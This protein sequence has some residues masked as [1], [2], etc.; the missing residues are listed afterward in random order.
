MPRRGFFLPAVLA[1]AMQS[2]LLGLAL[3][4]EFV[5]CSSRANA[6]FLS[7]SPAVDM[8]RNFQP[9]N[10]CT[11][12]NIPVQRQRSLDM[13]GHA[14]AHRPSCS[15]RNPWMHHATLFSVR[16]SGA[17]ASGALLNSPRLPPW[18]TERPGRFLLQMAA[19]EASTATANEGSSSTRITVM[20]GSE[21]R[22]MDAMSLRDAVEQ[23][24][25]DCL[26][27]VH[28]KVLSDVG[29]KRLDTFLS[30]SISILSRSA[31]SRIV[32]ANN[33]I[34]NGKVPKCSAKVRVGDAISVTLPPPPSTDAEPE[35]I[36][37]Q[38]LLED[39]HVVLVNKQV[40][41]L[42]ACHIVPIHLTH[43]FNRA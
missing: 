20:V 22:N 36:P 7:V 31:L 10:R 43:G 24:A 30:E 39:D 14:R 42:S 23:S 3:G 26:V 2:N 9:W 8:R 40:A 6:A 12:G 1:F 16:N 11:A 5:P 4:S 41:Y 18:R 27:T 32:K 17:A 15:S 13:T 35:D 21:E 28:I 33:A 38:V 34:L 29:A 37:L 19:R 25:D